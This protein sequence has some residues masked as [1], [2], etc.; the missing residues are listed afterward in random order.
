VFEWQGHHIARLSCQGYNT[1]AQ[2]DLLIDALTEELG[3]AAPRARRTQ[4]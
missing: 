3:L 2:M 4:G 1:R